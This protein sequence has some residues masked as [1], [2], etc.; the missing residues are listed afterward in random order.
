[1]SLFI[2]GINVS[3][4]KQIYLRLSDCLN[5]KFTQDIISF[6]AILMFILY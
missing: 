2:G 4:Y 1:M 6:F 5:M 3:L